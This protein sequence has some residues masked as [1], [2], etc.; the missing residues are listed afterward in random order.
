MEKVRQLLQGAT[1]DGLMA[2]AGITTAV[3]L[4]A[5]NERDKS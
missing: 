5:G 2:A 3:P 1:A 4:A